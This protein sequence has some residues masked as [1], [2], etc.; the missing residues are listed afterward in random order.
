[1]DNLKRPVIVAVIAMRVMQV[2]VDEI[3]D[4]VAMRHGFVAAAWTMNVIGAVTA[5]AMVRRADGGVLVTDIDRM[6]VDM[7]A[8]RMMQMTVVQII[9]VIAMADRD[10]AATRSMRMIVVGMMGK[11]ALCHDEILLSVLFAGMCNGVLDKIEHMPVGDRIDRGLAL[12][13]PCDQTGLQQH[14]EPCRNRSDLVALQSGEIADIALPGRK[15]E[16]SLQACR[17]RQR[18][19]HTRRVF[20]L[21]PV[22][23]CHS[24]ISTLYRT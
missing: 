7:I 16:E 14:L 21:L 17:I 8:V 4:V 18:L 11:F 19:E 2:T 6:L 20:Q 12:F 24:N 3:V 23:G 9:R 5:A 1:L 10:M 22:D 13:A 15:D